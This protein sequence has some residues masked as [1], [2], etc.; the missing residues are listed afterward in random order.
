MGKQILIRLGEDDLGQI[1]DGLRVRAESW[2][3]TERY[4]ETGYAQ[5]IIEECND[6]AEARSIAEH[7]ERIIE[8]VVKQHAEQERLDGERATG[9]CRES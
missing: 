6:A 7:Y 5:N 3:A 1:I 9:S 2:R 4:L 8:S